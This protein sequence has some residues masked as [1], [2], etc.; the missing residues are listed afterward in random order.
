MNAIQIPYIF[1]ASATE[2]PFPDNHFD[3]VFTDPPYY[4]NV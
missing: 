2:L 4:D 1:L 3:A